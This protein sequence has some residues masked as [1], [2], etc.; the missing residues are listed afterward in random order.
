ML[1]LVL[2]LITVFVYH[3]SI[4]TSNVYIISIIASH[5]YTWQL[6]HQPLMLINSIVIDLASED[7]RIGCR[8]TLKNVM[9]MMYMFDKGMYVSSDF[10]EF[11]P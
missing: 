6:S 11:A 2:M 3:T 4:P 7:D 8:A 10:W 1:I 5:S 9:L